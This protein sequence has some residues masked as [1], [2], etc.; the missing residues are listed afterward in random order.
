MHE[1]RTEIEIA[2]IPERIWSILI[3]FIAYPQWN[4]FIR[5][6][7]GE[8]KTGERL[9]AFIQPTG[10][11][12]MT[13]RPTVLVALPNQEFRWR[14]HFLLP[15]IFDG[16]HYFQIELIAPGRVRF[17]QGEKFSGL[18]VALAKSSL[19]GETKSGF[20]AMNQA[21]KVQAEAV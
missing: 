11:K 19:E 7:K 16:E 14:G 18:L 1:I 20:I 10:G 8:V 5:S 17:I 15:G 4:P 12:G 6:I 9:T 2:A 21:L 3:D 13:F